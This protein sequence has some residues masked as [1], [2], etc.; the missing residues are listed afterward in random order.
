MILSTDTNLSTRCEKMFYR[1]LQKALSTFFHTLKKRP[2]SYPYLT[3]DSFRSLADHI[4][5]ET[6]TFNPTSV[7]NGDVVFVGNPYMD[8]FFQKIHPHI[9]SK[10][11]L[12]QHN[13]DNPVDEH[14]AKYIDEK[15]VRFYAQCVFVSHAKIVPIPIGIANKHHGIEI[16]PELNKREFPKSKEKQP[17]IFFHF[18]VQ[19]NPTERGPAL[20][21]F[22]THPAMDTIHTFVP[23][24]SYKKI[25]GAY[26]F[27]ASPAGNALG[28]HRTWEALYLHT[29]P[30]VKRT[31]DAESCVALGMPIWMVDDWHELSAFSE[32]E[33]RAKY[34]KMMANANFEALFMDHWIRRIK[35]DQA[36]VKNS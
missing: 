31:V 30:I 19:T 6:G 20:E 12:I 13:G 15:I 28:S 5:D 14:I 36:S 21:Y 22:K 9:N 29:I 32:V 2:G 16:S 23:Y 7:R 34:E 11:I 18:S 24:K 25:L 33:L 3:G 8:D 27:T 4:H 26:C 1:V 35:N 17:R 10:Y